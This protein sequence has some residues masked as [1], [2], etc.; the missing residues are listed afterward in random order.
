[1]KLSSEQ[2]ERA[3]LQQTGKT[4]TL[5]HYGSFN[6]SNVYEKFFLEYDSLE[7][8]FKDLIF[9][10]PDKEM[11]ANSVLKH[12]TVEVMYLWFSNQIELILGDSNK[13]LIDLCTELD[14]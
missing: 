12:N 1:M 8:R 14:V 10:N 6:H 13:L 11:I 3:M 7:Y 5:S 2:F 9:D 4:V